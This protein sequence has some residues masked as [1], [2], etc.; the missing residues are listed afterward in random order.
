MAMG[1]K[2]YVMLL[3]VLFGL[4]IGGVT[5]QAAGGTALTGYPQQ[6]LP[7]AEESDDRLAAALQ[8]ALAGS[9]REGQ[10]VRYLYNRFDLNG[11]GQEEV[12]VLVLDPYFSG[13]GGSTALLFQPTGDAYRLVSQFRVL[14]PPVL[15]SPFSTH[16]WKDLIVRVSGGGS[17]TGWATLSFDG[18]RY[19]SNPTVA[20]RLAGEPDERAVRIVRGEDQALWQLEA[21]F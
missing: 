10:I 17:K 18:E 9:L 13:S 4:L 7:P 12:F 8:A 19:P 21:H 1:W 20:P 2:R 5:A 15:V 6:N 11:D 16:G 14:R 3:G